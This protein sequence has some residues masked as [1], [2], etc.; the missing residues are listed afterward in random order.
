MTSLETW[1]DGVEEWKEEKDEEWGGVVGAIGRIEGELEE[2]RRERERRSA[3]EEERQK[4]L[5]EEATRKKEA[6]E[7]Q[8]KR[9]KEKAEHL[10]LQIQKIGKWTALG[11]LFGAFLTAIALTIK[12]FAFLGGKGP[13]P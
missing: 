13:L 6:D 12:L 10:A 1:A 3:R 5:V 9:R 7:A 4:I 8:A 11:A 2:S